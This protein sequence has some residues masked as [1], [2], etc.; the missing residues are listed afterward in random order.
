MALFK[1][2][3]KKLVVSNGKRLEAGMT[4]EVSYNGSI[5]PWNTA[6]K[7][8]IKRQLKMKYNVDFPDGSINSINF[9]V[10]KL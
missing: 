6:T 7:T 4:A 1:V 10:E 3:T 8:E 2:T 9:N 5:L